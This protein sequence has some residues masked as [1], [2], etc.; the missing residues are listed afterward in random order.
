MVRAHPGTGRRSLYV[1]K[2]H[3]RRIPQLSRPESQALLGF[4]YRW[5]E[6]VK[7]S[8]RWRWTPG[9]VALWDERV[10]LHSIVDDIGE[11][12]GTRVLHRVTVLGDDPQP[13]ADAPTWDRH[14]SDK[15]AAS[16]YYGMAG[17]EF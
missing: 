14:R 7:F 9:D 11:A 8:C 17:F 16:G 3:G 6:Q 13:P 1:N 15:T 10:T 5:Q 4:L 2:Q 12:D